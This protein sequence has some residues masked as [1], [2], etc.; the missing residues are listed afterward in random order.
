MLVRFT[1]PPRGK[2]MRP[3][4]LIAPLT[5]PAAKSSA[6]LKKPKGDKNTRT[7]TKAGRRA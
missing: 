3:S 1:G 5:N 2:K 6:F 4:F 7:N